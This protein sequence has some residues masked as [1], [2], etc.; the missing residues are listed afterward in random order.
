MKN[1]HHTIGIALLLSWCAWAGAEPEEFPMPPRLIE[2]AIPSGTPAE[3]PEPVSTFVPPEAKKIRQAFMDHIAA[4]AAIS[5]EHKELVA[6]L[7]R[8]QTSGSSGE[9]ISQSL[10]MIYPEFDKAMRLLGEEQTD[11]AIGLLDGLAGQA[12]PFLQS[13]A[14][15]YK[16]RALSMQERYEDALPLLEK[17]TTEQ[18]DRT[19]HSGEAM[20][21]KAAA[22][23][24]TLDRKGAIRTLRDF[25]KHYPDAPERMR[26]GGQQM[27][28]DLSYLESGSIVDVQ[29]RMDYS[30]R[31]LDIE[32]S[33]DKTQQEQGR[34]VAMIDKLIKDAEDKENSGGGGG[35]SGGGQGSQPGQGGNPSGNN[36]PGGPA[37]QSSITPG[38][39][40]IGDLGRV[41]RGSES[42]GEARQRER[43]E[44]IAAIKARY[45]DRY[46]ELVEQY[47]R[48]LQEENR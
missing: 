41:I 1:K 5:P 46:Q 17:L 34:I 18:L 26:V 44:V 22:L 15:F 23:A 27:L 24:Q 2:M 11:Q 8:S 4:S 36:T 20:F 47:Y 19:L 13:Y 29:D 3:K 6:E 7:V 45:P 21:L 33:G 39:A 37:D 12:D 14:V 31:R 42:W 25:L 40:R 43:E 10:R 48:S 16:A 32:Q 35:S 30:R 28:D 38:Q 9:L